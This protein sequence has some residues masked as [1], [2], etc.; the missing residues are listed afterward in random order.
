MMRFKIQV[1]LLAFCL[2]LPVVAQA[3][4]TASL[5]NQGRR[6]DNGEGVPRDGA[7]AQQFYIA[8]ARANSIMAKN[9]LAYLWARQNGLLEEA[10]CLSAETL[11]A[12][13][14]NAYYLDTYGFILLR[15]GRL[16]DARHFFDKA[17]QEF[18]SYDDALE[19]MGDIA[20]R[21]GDN[22]AAKDFWQRALKA[23]R[24]EHQRTHL[25]AKLAGQP[26][27]LDA[28]P[29]FPLDAAGFGKECAMPT[30]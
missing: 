19:H 15:L 1:W 6:Y 27:D 8:A 10:L 13:P 23:A 7:K 9:N 18:P 11:Q 20:Y 26:D 3:E 17:L 2:L 22:A 12:Q 4:D 25:N 21:R 5:V 28:H 14:H 24:S 29:P 16:D 30:V